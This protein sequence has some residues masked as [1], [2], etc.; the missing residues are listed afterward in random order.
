MI[1]LVIILLL[2]FGIMNNS[3]MNIF[4]ILPLSFIIW[5]ISLSKVFQGGDRV[6][7]N[8][9]SNVKFLDLDIESGS[10]KVFDSGFGLILLLNYFLN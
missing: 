6:C 10:K 9:S 4:M 2:L 8:S 1:Q 7:L 3:S 5:N